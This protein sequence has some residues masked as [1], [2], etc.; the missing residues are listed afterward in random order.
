MSQPCDQLRTAADSIA[1][2]NPRMAQ[3]LKEYLA[4]LEAGARPDPKAYAARFPELG[5]ELLERLM[6]LEF[7]QRATS[8]LRHSE[9]VCSAPP[10]GAQTLGDFRILR[11]VGRGGMGVVYEAMQLSLGRRVALKILSHTGD[12]DEKPRRRFKNEVQ[13]AAQLHHG[14]IAPIYAV[15]C[16]GAV[17]YFAMQFIEGQTLAVIVAAIR[18]KVSTDPY[19]R[20]GADGPVATVN[21]QREGHA[22]PSVDGD[23]PH[24]GP[25]AGIATVAVFFRLPVAD[26]S[27]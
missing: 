20:T 16:E 12:L 18:E 8:G 7:I 22:L 13:A 15:G 17:H 25:P 9:G 21:S 3:A 23:T 6:G 19:F 11:E 1:L 24:P 10:L 5:D 2:D 14:N 26:G 27:I 4:A